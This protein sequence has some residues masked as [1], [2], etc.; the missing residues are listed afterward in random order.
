MFK[1]KLLVM[2]SQHEACAL[3]KCSTPSQSDDSFVYLNP[4]RSFSDVYSASS[5]TFAFAGMAVSMIQIG[6]FERKNSVTYKVYM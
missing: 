5:N 4:L 1:T 2:I 3:L 6:V